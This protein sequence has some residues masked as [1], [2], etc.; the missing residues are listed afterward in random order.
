MQVTSK[1]IDKNGGDS[2]ILEILAQLSYKQQM[3]IHRRL[4][5]WLDTK[6]TK[7]TGNKFSRNGNDEFF[8]TELGQYILEKADNNISITKVRAA[9]TKIKGSLS[10]DVIA[11]REER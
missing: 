9:L 4:S 8:R 7:S 2:A 3:E 5:Q 6:S 10:R 11:E 1:S